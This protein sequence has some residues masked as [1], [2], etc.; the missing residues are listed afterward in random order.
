[1]LVD[2][3]FLLRRDGLK[4]SITEFLSLLELLNKRIIRFDIE[5]FYYLS[6]GCL[7]KDESLY[8]RFDRA[9]S[10]HFKGVESLFGPDG[11]DIPEE[12]LRKQMELGLSEEEKAQIE[13]MGGWEKLMETLKKRLEEQEERH[14]GGSKMDRYR[15]HVAFWCVWL[16]PG[17]D[18]HRTAGLTPPQGG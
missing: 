10:A 9:F 18:S 3:F 13:A 15:W 7:I 17:R 4:V 1:M 6:R 2:F 12:W 14:Q 5:Q 11:A 8:D 16:Q